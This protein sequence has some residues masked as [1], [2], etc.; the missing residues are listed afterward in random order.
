MTMRA[1]AALIAAMATAPEGV[2]YRRKGNRGPHQQ[3]VPALSGDTNASDVL[4]GADVS[5]EACYCRFGVQS[6]QQWP[7]AISTGA[8]CIGG[9]G[10][11][12]FWIDRH[13]STIKTMSVWFANGNSNDYIKSIRVTWEDGH[14]VQKGSPTGSPRSFTFNAGEWVVGDLR[15]SGNGI[16]TR[17][18][19]IAFDTSADRKFDVGKRDPR[20]YYFPTGGSL[21]RPVHMAGLSGSSGS[22]IDRMGVLFWKPIADTSY[23]NINYPTLATQ[24]RLTSPTEV[25]SRVFCNDGP[26]PLPATERTLS[27][28]VTVGREACLTTSL[29]TQFS[30]SITVKGGIPFIKEGEASASWGLTAGLGTKNCKTVT[31]TKNE[32]L[33]FPSFD[34]PPYTRVRQTFSQWAGSLSSLPWTATLQ[35]TTTDGTTFQQNKEG[36]YRGVSYN[37]VHLAYNTDSDVT[38]C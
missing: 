16:G 8:G 6:W 22:D 14:T 34:I 31:S 29:E 36:F 4:S 1:L 10:G 26:H 38:Q 21:T 18:G 3:V 33:K 17:L 25:R 2:R 13:G 12:E 9:C 32:T 27:E 11:S 20:R 19:S 15:L 28:V 37:D 5:I 7:L 24:G 30:M 35:V 23:L